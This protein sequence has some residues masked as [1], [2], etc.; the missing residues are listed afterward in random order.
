LRGSEQRRDGEVP[1][2]VAVEVRDDDRVREEADRIR[3]VLHEGAVPLLEVHGR[4]VVAGV[5]HDQVRPVRAIQ[6]ARGNSAR[7]LRRAIE[8]GRAER[9]VAEVAEHG[10]LPPEQVGRGEVVV[11]V[12]VEVGDGDVPGLERRIAPS[13]EVEPS[14]E[15]LPID[16]GGGRARLANPALGGDVPRGNGTREHHETPADR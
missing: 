14:R 3:P 2:A 8:D 16:G 7:A 6:I 10:E 1:V 11:A 9:S 5:D 12:S 15:Q 4:Q 13:G